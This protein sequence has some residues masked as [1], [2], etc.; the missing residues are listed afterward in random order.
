MADS[1]DEHARSQSYTRLQ[2]YMLGYTY[3]GKQKFGAKNQKQTKG[4]NSIFFAS[5][6]KSLKTLVRPHVEHSDSTQSPYYKKD[7]ELLEKV[8]RLLIVHQA[9]WFD[10][11]VL[12]VGVT[13]LV[14]CCIFLVVKLLYQVGQKYELL[15]CDKHKALAKK[16]KK[17]I[18]MCR[19]DIVHQVQ[20]MYHI[21]VTYF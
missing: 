3:S 4:L 11:T 12:G 7:K 17:D 13:R 16:L 19:P 18:S 9:T 21:T 8:Q 15:N 20:F 1:R 10:C 14:N 2:N 6:Q 5:E